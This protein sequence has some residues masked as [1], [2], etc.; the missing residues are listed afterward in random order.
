M[1]S[2]ESCNLVMIARGWWA[3]YCELKRKLGMEGEFE[4]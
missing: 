4:K 2:E 1:A 3:E